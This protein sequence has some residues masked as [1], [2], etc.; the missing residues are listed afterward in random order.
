MSDRI[1]RVLAFGKL[2]V[3]NQGHGRRR[4]DGATKEIF[5]TLPASATAV[6]K[7]KKR[8]KRRRRRRRRHRQFL[9]L[10]RFTHLASAAT[11][12]TRAPDAIVPARIFYRMER[13]GTRGGWKRARR[14]EL[15][16]RESGNLLSFF[17]SSLSFC[18]SKE[19]LTLI[20]FD[21]IQNTHFF[22]FF[23]FFFLFLSRFA[24]P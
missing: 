8:G 12:A 6:A 24:L 2:G 20:A 13:Y 16:D 21:K 1:L 3:G 18:V 9:S 22:F 4:R 11:N 15:A 7:N 23:F 5:E 19:N 14:R 10:S 17:L